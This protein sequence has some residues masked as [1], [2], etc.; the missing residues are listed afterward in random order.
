MLPPG[1]PPGLS[2]NPGLQRPPNGP[3]YRVEKKH[4]RSGSTIDTQKIARAYDRGNI[5]GELGQPSQATGASQYG[6]RP[7]SSSTAAFYPQESIKQDPAG[8]Q[9]VS[10]N[11]APPQD[12]YQPL[13]PAPRPI[14]VPST[15]IKQENRE[16]T[17]GN[18][19]RPILSTIGS[20]PSSYQ[21][22]W[23]PSQSSSQA[24]CCSSGPVGSNL[25]PMSEWAFPRSDS[26][27][28]SA[29]SSLSA[30]V[31][32]PVS[33]SS[34]TSSMQAHY[35]PND[36]SAQAPDGVAP[37]SETVPG[38][39]SR[40]SSANNA[41]AP[42]YIHQSIESMPGAPHELSSNPYLNAVPLGNTPNEDPLCRC[43]PDCSCVMCPVHPYNSATYDHI[44]SLRSILEEDSAES[45][46]TPFQ[47]LEQFMSPIDVNG[48]TQSLYDAFPNGFQSPTFAL[49]DSQTP[50]T[51]SSTAVTTLVAAPAGYGSATMPSEP[52]N[53]SNYLTFEFP[54]GE[55][56]SCSD[57][58]GRCMCDE[59]CNCVG[60]MT[61]KAN[62]DSAPQAQVL[63]TFQT[64][65]KPAES[66][67]TKDPNQKSCCS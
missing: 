14:D 49:G 66:H 63:P 41:M 39:G 44:N 53:S 35:R 11:A 26:R 33:D 16:P 6:N 50:Y 34:W 27:N 45:Q 22:I 62:D 40:P 2:Q 55:A 58:S 51:S 30:G 17:S 9:L 24:P 13:R 36:V 15:S 20:Y 46:N 28:W 7:R 31:M 57:E 32:T 47:G 54:Y 61:H 29:R 10:L 56:P 4:S 65:T 38:S 60:C 19:P 42:N 64:Q 23:Q 5:L 18:A 48:M 1:P 21:N 3:L 25:E 12:P 43:G 59:N 52:F 67:E 37:N 8:M